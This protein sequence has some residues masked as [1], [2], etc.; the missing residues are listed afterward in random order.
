M[1][2]YRHGPTAFTVPELSDLFARSATWRMPRD[3][4]DWRDLVA[5][6]PLCVSAWDGPHLVGFARLPTDFVRWANF[7]E[8][9]VAPAHQ[10]Q[11]IG[12]ELVRRLL[13][14]PR[15]ARVRTFWLGTEDAFAFYERLGFR[16]DGNGHGMLLVRR[17]RDVQ[18]VDSKAQTL[19]S[20]G[21]T[22]ETTAFVTST[23]RRL[24]GTLRASGAGGV[25]VM[26]HGFTSDRW[27][28]GRFPRM[29]AALARTGISSLAFDFGGY[30]ESDD[31]VVTLDSQV[32]DLRA[33]LAFVRER[34]LGPVA[35]LGH[36]LGSYVALLG[37]EPNVV[38]MVLTGAATG[39]MHYR[40]EEY[41]SAEQLRT[42][43]ET[44]HLVVSHREGPRRETVI[45]GQL[46]RDFQELDAA[47]LFSALRCPVLVVHGDGDE[48]ERQLLQHTKAREPL[49]PSGS[50]VEVL[51]GTGHDLLGVY[52]RV[53]DL[54]VE[55]FVRRLGTAKASFTTG[56]A[57]AVGG[58]RC[59]LEEPGDI[60]HVRADG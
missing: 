54:A 11:G 58:M 57:A 12:T 31:V 3:T 15:V 51:P 41:F 8:V 37:Y 38:A 18:L 27:S 20:G 53:I 44:G 29:A 60:V 48:E 55:W 32:E 24:V 17:D 21:G 16:R 34:G 45:A 5:N 30:G 19:P 33:A 36:S 23:G 10:R 4:S 1:I 39:P 35:V 26:A 13:D 7:G 25:V 52:G 46:L 59:A 42:L 9:V 28:K 56:D 43:R 50:R 40:W 47:P 49:L 2:V 22:P 14:H 6:T